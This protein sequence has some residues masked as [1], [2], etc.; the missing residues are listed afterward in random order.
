M[1]LHA[2]R[3]RYHLR[4]RWPGIAMKLAH[5]SRR[6]TTINPTRPTVAAEVSSGSFTNRV[7][8]VVV[9]RLDVEPE[10][11]RA[12]TTLLS[13]GE[14]DRARHFAFER[15]RRRFVVARAGL[16][17]QLA[18]R[19]G[20]RPEAIE[21]VYGTHGKPALA[22]QRGDPDLRFNVSHCENVALYAFSY[23]REIGVDIEAIRQ[24][25]DAD[26]IAL[27]FFSRWEIEAY[28]ALESRDRP[29]GFLNCWTRKEAF[30]KA[31]GDGLYRPLDS[32]DVSL[33][34]GEPAKILRVGDTPGGDCGWCLSANAPMHGFAAA[35]V[36][37]RR[38]G[39]DKFAACA[40]DSNWTAG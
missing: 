8:E 16:R 15:D 40:S 7:F 1:G 25:S 31:L 32:F 30:I 14:R 29:L 3:G 4:A 36:Y 21:L 27:R 39:S 10:V 9:T 11:V 18:L 23:G 26:E 17:E 13:D 6:Q 2:R 22:R 35:V 19:V 5:F 34:P 28:L 33:V 12:K 24:V 20:R 38:E 37:E